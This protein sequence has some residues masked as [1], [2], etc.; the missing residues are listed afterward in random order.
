MLTCKV[1]QGKLSFKSSS[2]AAVTRLCLSTLTQCCFINFSSLAGFLDLLSCYYYMCFCELQIHMDEDLFLTWQMQQGSIGVLQD[3]PCLFYS[4]RQF[5]AT[6]SIQ[7]I[8]NQ[9]CHMSFSCPLPCFSQLPSYQS[10]PNQIPHTHINT[11][12]NVL[13]ISSQI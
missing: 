13:A 1:L 8:L 3:F 9:S 11:H 12:T 2:L 6:K 5:S 10:S 4:L 7:S